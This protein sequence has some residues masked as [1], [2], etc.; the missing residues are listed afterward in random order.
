MTLTLGLASQK[1]KESW[2]P[3]FI[4]IFNS[5]GD[6]EANFSLGIV[7]FYFLGIPSL[8]ISFQE[9]RDNNTER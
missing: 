5:M 3:I 4:F 9:V 1:Q 6:W 8:L 7:S 2:R